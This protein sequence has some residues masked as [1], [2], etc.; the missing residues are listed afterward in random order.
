MEWLNYMENAR[1]DADA[2][3]ILEQMRANDTLLHDAVELADEPTRA[4]FAAAIARAEAADRR[5]ARYA[6]LVAEV[7]EPA[8]RAELERA[9][10]ERASARASADARSLT[11]G[12]VP[13]QSLRAV[14]A[15]L[16]RQPGGARAIDGGTFVDL[17]SGAGKVV[18]AAAL[19][20]RFA[21]ARGIELLPELDALARALEARWRA[22]E[23]VE[24]ELE[25]AG[26]AAAP[27]TRVE[28][29]LGSVLEE[30][31][32]DATLVLTHCTCFAG[33]LLAALAR[34]AARLA[35][36]AFVVTTSRVLPGGERAP[37]AAAAAGDAFEYL[38]C[39]KLEWPYHI[40]R[41]VG[42]PVS[43]AS[44]VTTGGGAAAS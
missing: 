33:E 12:E 29:A 26:D 2:D 39:V 1:S 15:E 25:R 10:R 22:G 17:G 3:E 8:V 4:R 32:D 34:R 14:L 37:G 40:H 28:F 11:Y 19:E 9:E 35:P 20:R 16:R 5:D 21:R 38:G 18:I 43:A 7:S 6:A 24:G 36:G 13:P 44:I 41:R 23:G 31:W 42:V 30:R 27:P